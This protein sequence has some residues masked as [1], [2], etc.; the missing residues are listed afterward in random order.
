MITVLFYTILF[1]A[2]SYGVDVIDYKSLFQ[3]IWDKSF[4]TIQLISFVSSLLLIDVFKDD[5]KWYFYQIILFL[6]LNKNIKNKI[7]RFL[8]Q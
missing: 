3:E 8:W 6:K 1:G 4:G 5:I 2:I 7:I